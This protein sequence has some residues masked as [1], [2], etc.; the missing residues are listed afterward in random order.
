MEIGHP[1]EHIDTKK[2]ANAAREHS[3]ANSA[4]W[5]YKQKK[6]QTYQGFAAVVARPGIEPGTS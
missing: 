3:T 6:R 1:A 4:L 2:A 5:M